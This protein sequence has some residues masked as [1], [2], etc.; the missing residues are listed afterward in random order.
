M[1]SIGY[2][3]RSCGKAIPQL[4]SQEQENKAQLYQTTCEVLRPMI[5]RMT[6]FMEF[7]DKLVAVFTEA[8]SGI[9]PEI[10]DKDYFPSEEFLLT[11]A[12][13]L[14]L[15]VSLDIMK[16]FKGSMSNDLSMYKRLL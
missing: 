7:R 8:L 12:N 9:I 2:A 4:Q 1:L 3:F 14:D 13:L 16:N 11:L 10:R 6:K 5:A 15:T